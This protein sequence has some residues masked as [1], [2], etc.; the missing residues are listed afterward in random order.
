MLATL[1]SSSMPCYDF[2]FHIGAGYAAFF[3]DALLRLLLPHRCG[4]AAFFIDAL[5]RLLLPHRCWLRCVLHRCLVTTFTSTSMLATL[6]SS[7]MQ[8]PRYPLPKVV[9]EFHLVQQHRNEIES[10]LSVSTTEV[11]KR[12]KPDYAQ[13]AKK[14]NRI[15][16]LPMKVGSLTRT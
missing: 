12:A 1:R 2:Y 15:R 10:S 4:Y 5:L 14:V 16:C 8:E 11:A 7:S 6:R 3:I 9:N 13:G